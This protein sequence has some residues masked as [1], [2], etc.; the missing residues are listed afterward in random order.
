M[1]TRMTVV[2]PND[3]FID[4]KNKAPTEGDPAGAFQSRLS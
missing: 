1:T 3:G 2:V 4:R